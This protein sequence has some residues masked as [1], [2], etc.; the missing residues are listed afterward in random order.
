MPVAPRSRKRT[1]GIV[2]CHFSP[3]Y[4]Y[5]AV[6]YPFSQK[7]YSRIYRISI[8]SAT[9]RFHAARPNLGVTKRYVT[10]HFSCAK[11]RFTLRAKWPRGAFR[12]SQQRLIIVIKAEREPSPFADACSLRAA[13]YGEL[14]LI[15][16]RDD[17]SL[18]AGLTFKRWRSLT[19][20][21][22]SNGVAVGAVVGGLPAGLALGLVAD[23][24]QAELLS[25][26]VAAGNRR[27]GIGKRLLE[28]WTADARTKGA[29]SISVRFAERG[30]RRLA[31][32][33]LL[34]ASGWTE[35]SE[36]GLVVLGRAGSM[37]E[38]VGAWA[39]VSERLSKQSLYSFD[40]MCLTK[41][42]VERV[43][44][45]LA[46]SDATHMHGPLRLWQRLEQGVSCLVRR[47]GQL[48]GWVLAGRSRERWSALAETGADQNIQGAKVPLIEYYE[49]YLDPSYW[50]T[51]IAVG[52][53]YHCYSKQ[54]E[55]F[56]PQSLALYYT[57]PSRPRMV[58]LTRRRFAPIAER[59]ETIWKSD[60]PISE[61][62]RRT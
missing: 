6:A 43:D 58:H 24:G 60:G 54:V 50:H 34:S 18:F 23:D 10:G 22:P 33:A 41:A 4:R 45:L 17:A 14:R 53:Y 11:C 16:L 21:L 48:V 20:K 42:D 30:E 56:G 59:V 38:A 52:A 31:L 40:P 8:A 27:R 55:L 3:P 5:H 28:T 29:L 62:S 51:A 13:G 2:S 15:S 46:L 39:P 12:P 9:D 19:H 35:P 7:I 47:E 26:F 36:D 25:V 49:A 1:L 57:G 61:N 32:D 37:V 44:S